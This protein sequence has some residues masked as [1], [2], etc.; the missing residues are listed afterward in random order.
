MHPR[1]GRGEAQEQSHPQQ[2]P[3]SLSSSFRQD[4]EGTRLPSSCLAIRSLRAGAPGPKAPVS[5][6]ANPNFPETQATELM[7]AASPRSACQAKD[8]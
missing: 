1:K 2:Y 5:V 7:P 4:G 8:R 3:Q 6:A